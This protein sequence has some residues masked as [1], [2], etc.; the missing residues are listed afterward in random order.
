[1]SFYFPLDW[2]KNTVSDSSNF[3]FSCVFC[4]QKDA[5]QKNLL[6]LYSKPPKDRQRL[7]PHKK[8]WQKKLLPCFWQ[9]TEAE[10]KICQYC[11]LDSILITKIQFCVSN[12]VRKPVSGSSLRK[13]GRCQS[14]VFPRGGKKI[15]QSVPSWSEQRICYAWKYVN[16]AYK[17]CVLELAKGRI[18]LVSVVCVL[19]GP[20]PKG[21]K[22]TQDYQHHV[23]AS[24]CKRNTV[25]FSAFNYFTKG[26]MGNQIFDGHCKGI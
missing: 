14:C 23:P 8:K 3:L 16:K 19:G 17:Y 25:A 21:L 10:S 24:K 22:G 7:L 5:N 13:T 9:F 4:P 11:L 26:G 15:F 2:S 20:E 1:M 18:A 6:C 12:S